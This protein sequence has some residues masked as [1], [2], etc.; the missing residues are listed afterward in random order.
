MKNIISISGFGWSGSTAARDLLREYSD[1]THFTDNNH[2]FKE[3]SLSYD[4]NGFIDLY[5]SLVQ[6][7]N[8]LVLDKA[9]KDHIKYFDSRS[10]KADFFNYYGLNIDDF[11]KVNSK[12]LHNEFMN[13]L[14]LF[15]YTFSSRV[16]FMYKALP[17]KLL[18]HILNRTSYHNGKSLFSNITEEDFFRE[19][20]AFHN[21]LFNQILAKNDLLLEKA[22]PVNNINLVSNFFDNLKVLVVDRDPRDT[23]VEMSKRKTLFWGSGKNITNEQV[24]NFALW[25][26]AMST[27]GGVNELPSNKLVKLKSKAVVLK[28]NFEDLVLNYDNVKPLIEELVDKTSNE[29]ICKYQYFNPKKSIKNIGIWRDYEN[30]NHINIIAQV[31]GK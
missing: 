11:F 30:Q 7:W 18:S 25:K 23:F 12:S 16:N 13:K 14:T 29:H 15:N 2:S 24:Y 3:Y 22:V 28:I 6:N 4:P 26:K 27:R 10:S 31:F 8:F 20:K 21:N 19:V 9:I 1:I 5:S 17:A